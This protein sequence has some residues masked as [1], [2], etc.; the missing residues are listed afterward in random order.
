MLKKFFR[1]TIMHPQLAIR[2][3]WMVFVVSGTLVGSAVFLSLRISR[4]ALQDSIVSRGNVDATLASG[5]FY[6][7]M[8]LEDQWEIDQIIATLRGSDPSVN[9]V[10]T[11]L[12]SNPNRWLSERPWVSLLP[13]AEGAIAV[14]VGAES[15]FLMGRVMDGDEVLG[16]VGLE[17]SLDGVQALTR[18]VAII[19]GV[20]VVVML[21]G[22]MLAMILYLRRAVQLPLQET[23]RMLDRVGGGDLTARLNIRSDDEM[24][25]MAAAVN[26]AVEGMH[27][28]LTAI[29]QHADVLG[30]SSNLAVATA[31]PIRR[32][33]LPRLPF[34]ASTKASAC[35]MR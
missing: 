29:A 22:V 33:A 5:L 17:L 12:A 16:H 20:F 18:R 7:P 30:G 28:A 21:A 10:K 34:E 31:K 19:L 23:V 2:M 35:P 13:R 8:L 25:H 27:Q 14:E 24:G 3:G 15:L 26:R 32:S 1:M 6:T 11:S 4:E 9:D